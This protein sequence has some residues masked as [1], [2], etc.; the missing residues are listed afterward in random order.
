MLP[1]ATGLG[2]RAHRLLQP[3][4]GVADEVPVPRQRVHGVAGPHRRIAREGGDVVAHEAVVAQASPPGMEGPDMETPGHPGC[5]GAFPAAR[6][7]E[8]EPPR[9][10][11]HTDLN[12]ARL[13]IPPRAHFFGTGNK[14]P[15]PKVPSG[16]PRKTVSPSRGRP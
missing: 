9:R 13:P 10:L 15:R 16:Y 6:E 2:D 4:Q 7:G 1:D 8:L 12:R 14:S 3:L 5:T 11:R